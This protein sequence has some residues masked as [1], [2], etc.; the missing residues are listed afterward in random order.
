MFG[1][2]NNMTDSHTDLRIV[3]TKAAIRDALTQLIE[4]KGFETI[5]VKDI[6]TK[7]KINR[8]TF[9][10]H[11]KDKYDLLEQSQIEIIRGIEK[12]LKQG[13]LINLTEYKVIDKPL[14]FVADIF[15]YLNE[16]AAFM[17]AIL[18]PKGDP[19]F[20]TKIKVFM[21][22]KIFEKNLTIPLFDKE[23]LL[24]PSEYLLSYIASAHLGVVQQWLLEGRKQSPEEM[25]MI[26]STITFNGP[27]YA[28]GVK[29]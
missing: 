4:E 29:K 15:H 1:G 2:G 17:K 28:A 7:A 22:E 18:G 10:L 20:Q 8:G 13:S 24:V 23:K 26:L 19:S 27:M 5:T 14:P 6:T 21:W 11:Y 25:A 3:R 16:H 9:Y 12:I